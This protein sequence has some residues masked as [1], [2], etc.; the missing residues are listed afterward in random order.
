MSQIS[1]A[2][3]SP[4]FTTLVFGARVGRLRRALSAPVLAAPA[5]APAGPI[6]VTSD[7]QRVDKVLG[8]LG[9]GLYRRSVLKV[10]TQTTA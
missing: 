9:D 4:V 10:Y 5:A 1:S 2:K 6:A 8:L 7:V 3:A